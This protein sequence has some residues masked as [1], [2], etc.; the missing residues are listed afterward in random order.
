M[1]APGVSKCPKGKTLT[2][3]L[4]SLLLHAH[5]LELTL[6]TEDAFPAVSGQRNAP[7]AAC[8]KQRCNQLAAGMAAGDTFSQRARRQEEH[9]ELTPPFQFP[10][11]V[12]YIN[13]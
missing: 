6:L 12:S 11:L 1:L 8:F 3:E 7:W 9:R 10:F 5:A 2:D 4:L 13:Q